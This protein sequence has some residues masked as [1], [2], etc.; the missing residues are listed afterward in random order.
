MNL[1]LII[2]RA[3]NRDLVVAPPG[4]IVLEIRLDGTPSFAMSNAVVAFQSE[5]ED[6]FLRRTQAI[7]GGRGCLFVQFD[8]GDVSDKEQ[9]RI[10]GFF[11]NPANTDYF[12]RR[13]GI[14]NIEVKRTPKYT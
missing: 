11:A 5:L 14:T 12:R 7:A 1:P 4:R 8:L 9:C 6:L 13:Y 3:K 2:D 10:D